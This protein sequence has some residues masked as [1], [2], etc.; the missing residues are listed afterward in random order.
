M[1]NA[2]R[3]TIID[4][5]WFY[6]GYDVQVDIGFTSNGTT[7]LIVIP[8]ITI[9]GSVVMKDIMYSSIIP[10]ISEEDD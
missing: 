5:K 8:C 10:L 1:W 2:E 7:N 9:K 3:T 4:V 6:C